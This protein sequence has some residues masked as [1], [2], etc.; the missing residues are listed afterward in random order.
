M[1]SLAHSCNTR[2]YPHNYG[3]KLSFRLAQ[4]TQIGRKMFIFT[5]IYID[6]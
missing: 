2:A 1:A 5:D 4:T 3:Y 6:L